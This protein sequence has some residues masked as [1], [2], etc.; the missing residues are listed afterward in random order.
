[1]THTLIS[2]AAYR[3]FAMAA[4]TTML[5]STFA[6]PSA[7][8]AATPPVPVT[9]DGG[10]CVRGTIISHDEK[11]IT[12]KDSNGWRVTIAPL[13]DEGNAQN[14]HAQSI[15]P[16]DKGQF[17]FKGLD[18]P[19]TYRVSLETDEGWEAVTSNPFD[20]NLDFRNENCRVVRFKMRRL[21]PVSVLKID[22]YHNPL[23]GWTIMARPAPGNLFALPIT[24]TTGVDGV[25]NFKL[26]PGKWIF[27]ERGPK[28]VVY[29]PIVPQNGIQ[30]LD[31]KA[32]GPYALRFKNEVRQLGCIVAAKF[33]VPENGDDAFPL[34][35]WG[36]KVLRAD[37]TV[38]ARGLTDPTGMV[39]FKDL[40]LGPYTVVEE[41]RAGWIPVTYPSVPVVLT[42]DAS[43]CEM[44]E[45]HNAED[46]EGFVIT[47]RKIDTNGKIGL[48]GWVITATPMVKGGY[49]PITTTTDGEGFYK[50]V[51]PNDDYRIP[52]SRYKVCE[53]Q[54]A[55]WQPHTATCQ[56]AVMPLK[57][58]KAVVLKPFENQQ[59]G[60]WES[61]N[62]KAPMCR[63]QYVVVKGD[64]WNS[65]AD[66]YFV[67]VKQ[68]AASNP[69]LSTRRPLAIYRG[70]TIC[71][72]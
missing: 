33:D 18:G 10:F 20:V 71:V 60:H 49:G 12:N 30:V 57:T 69:R 25:I 48:P 53:E 28:G 37:G 23:K 5:C 29:T 65:V 67:T 38:A 68:L 7:A 34:V 17:E 72:P 21:V 61:V 44:V 14:D 4:A 22:E 58:G 54:R 40:P 39:T 42:R 1:M 26:S 56:M 24:G 70:R 47:G 2:H 6:A 19:T 35:G 52:G 50:F 62:P 36:V 27:M 51:L 55:G 45:F 15:A 66:T 9:G 32:P 16:N 46:H 41:Q 31:V 59:V 11:P 63:I 8:F 43:D 13:D 3:A 64:T